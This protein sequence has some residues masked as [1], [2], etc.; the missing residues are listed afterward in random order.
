MGMKIKL[1]YL[2]VFFPY[3]LGLTAE[4]SSPAD[5]EQMPWLVR[6][7]QFENVFYGM[8]IGTPSRLFF[9][10]S[11]RKG[12]CKTAVGGEQLSPNR[13]LSADVCSQEPCWGVGVAELEKPTS[14]TPLQYSQRP[15]QAGSL[16]TLMHRQNDQFVPI[17][18]L[19]QARSGPF[20]YLPYITGGD[21]M[22]PV[23]DEDGALVCLTVGKVCVQPEEILKL[24]QPRQEEK[25]KAYPTAFS[26]AFSFLLGGA[27][28]G[29]IED[30]HGAFVLSMGLGF[31]V[32]WITLLGRFAFL[33]HTGVQTLRISES[34]LSGVFTADP[35]EARLEL[36]CR[37]RIALEDRLRLEPAVGLMV[38]WLFFT[39]NGP[40]L[41]SKQ[42][43]CD[44][45]LDAC[46]VVVRDPDAY[47]D[48]VRRFGWGLQLGLDL[49]NDSA[50]I[51]Y[52]F[53]PAFAAAD[54]GDAHLVVV[55]WSY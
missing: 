42:P 23:L 21:W 39:A 40:A 34:S 1:F 3:G 37:L 6:V 32:K 35:Y 30:D 53:I 51:G 19:V 33:F 36:E 55:G 16:A 4:P 7:E 52:R 38:G 11:L 2:L 31:T 47:L 29:W 22:E 14:A 25:E 48:D 50:A 46:P 18:V 10:G 12:A 45:Y 13:I 28:G 24:V 9:S 26:P 20:F 8:A 15:I 44:P 27:W 5:Y 54:I 43:G 49:V 17:K 41:F